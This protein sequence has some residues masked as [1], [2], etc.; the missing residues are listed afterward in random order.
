M[1]IKAEPDT[2]LAEAVSI[3][4]NK[5]LKDPSRLAYLKVQLSGIAL[6]DLDLNSGGPVLHAQKILGNILSGIFV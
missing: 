6:K 3:A 5:I 1:G 4:S 2:D